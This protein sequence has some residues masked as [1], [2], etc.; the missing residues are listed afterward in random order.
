MKIEP[1]VFPSVRAKH[2]SYV[3]DF[4]LDNN[5]TFIQGDSGVGKSAVYSFLEELSA[6]DGRI[7]CYN[8]LDKSKG[9]KQAIR[10]AKGKLFV[11]DNADVLLDDRQRGQIALDEKNQYI[12]FGRNPTGLLLSLDEIYELQSVTENGITTFTL[13]KGI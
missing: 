3:V 1:V 5:I 12:L 11:I 9:Y 4:T 10:N 2:T 7:K 6:E 13:Q 8:Y